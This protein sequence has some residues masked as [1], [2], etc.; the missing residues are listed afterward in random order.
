MARCITSRMVDKAVDF[1]KL[2]FAKFGLLKKC[3]PV[4]NFQE[5]YWKISSRQISLNSGNHLQ[6]DL[7]TNQINQNYQTIKDM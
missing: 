2:L 6:T 7:Q 3:V 5:I 1:A 4:H